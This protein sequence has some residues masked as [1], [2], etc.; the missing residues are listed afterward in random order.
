MTRP[1]FG[2][3]RLQLPGVG[4]AEKT[5]YRVMGVADPAHYLHGRIVR[6]ALDAWPELRP[7][8]ILDAGCGRGDYVF[9]LARRYPDAHVV[10]VDVDEPLIQRNR[11]MAAK[12][13]ITNVEF[14]VADLVTVRFPAPFD[15]V[16]SVDVL[17]HIVEQERALANIRSQLTPTGRVVFHI[18]TLRE[19]P[20]PFSRHLKGFHEWA[21]HE[22]IAEDRTADQFV[23]VMRRAG[24]DVLTVRRTFGRYTGE[25]AVS[26]F[27]LAFENTLRN[28]IIQG[29]LAPV[30]R[31]LAIADDLSL[32]RTRYAVAVTAR[33][34]AGA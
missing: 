18:P 8:R 20:V 23:E 27:A 6:K 26:L 4:L 28:R 10:G 12:L 31:V 2:E 13:G 1:R 7:K 29:L 21:E 33:P 30:A 15:L 19:K 11:Q 5:L 32:E 9:Y 34:A 14:G 3:Q 25:L 16:V 17:E 24:Y 22:H